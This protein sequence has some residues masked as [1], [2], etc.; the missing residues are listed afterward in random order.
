MLGRPIWAHELSV[1]QGK[2]PLC[3]PH[4][5]G[6]HYAVVVPGVQQADGTL[7]EDAS[8]FAISCTSGALAKCLRM[9]Y[10]PWELGSDGRS[11]RSAYNAC[12]RM[13][14]AD[15]TGTGVPYTENG[16]LIDVYDF[17]GVQQPEYAEGQSFEAGWD[18]RGAVCVS[19]ARVASK[20]SLQE[21]EAAVPRLRG[22]VGAACTESRARELGALVFN[23]SM[24][25]ETRTRSTP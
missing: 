13:V 10:R 12:I 15:Y 23:R 19:H 2:Q 17:V 5:D 7:A 14:R 9:G 1:S 20:V 8:A 16:R 18:E 4:S 24:S 22:N 25:L 21:L 11:L 6:T 3:E